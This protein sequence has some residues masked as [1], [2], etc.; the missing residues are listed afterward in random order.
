MIAEEVAAKFEFARPGFTLMGYEEVAIPVYRLRLRALVLERKPIP[1]IQEFVLKSLRAGITTAPDVAAFMGLPDAV[2]KQ[3]FS[4]LVLAENVH[5]SGGDGRVHSWML[6]A[7]GRDALAA[8]ETSS[9][10]EATFDIDYDGLLRRATASNAYLYAPKDIRA[11][12][13]LEVPAV[14]NRAPDP[15]ELAFG[16]VAHALKSSR[17]GRLKRDLLS[18]VMIE[19]RTRLYKRAVALVYRGMVAETVQ[20]AI[21]VDGTA[22][23]EYES[24]FAKHRLSLNMGFDD[25]PLES[26]PVPAWATQVVGPAEAES[27]RRSVVETQARRAS[28][29][30]R[31]NRSETQKAREQARAELEEAEAEALEAVKKQTEAQVRFIKVFEHPELLQEALKESQSR[32]LIISP[33]LNPVVVNREFTTRLEALLRR[34]V[35]VYIGHGI[36][37]ENERRNKG[38]DDAAQRSLEHLSS[39]YTN[40]HF[41]RF[42]DTHAK[43]LAWDSKCAVLTS[44]NWLSFKG[45]WNRGYRD[46]QGIVVTIPSKVN[47]K[48]AEELPR[49]A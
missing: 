37:Q 4:D 46:E 30:E 27:L 41:K 1:T 9:P 18:I 35:S 12:G 6:T 40:F 10:E 24:A 34:G 31:L 49:F 39:R 3:T 21:A 28:L 20:V 23:P 15:E 2:V 25:P 17:S 7:K 44:F 29:E 22:S 8:A 13:L 26:I 36:S 16:E 11:E 47:E 43:V 19:R 42:G 38:A 33:W 32:L 48:F 45:D 14:P 5:L